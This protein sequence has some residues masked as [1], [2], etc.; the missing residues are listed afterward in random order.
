MGIGTQSP[1]HLHVERGN[2]PLKVSKQVGTTDNEVVT[3]FNG[4]VGINTTNPLANL[5]IE[6]VG[7]NRL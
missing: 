3:L 7:I 1:R 5:Q 2:I 6:V 4:K